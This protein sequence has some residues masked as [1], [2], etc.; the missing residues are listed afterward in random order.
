MYQN[1]YPHPRMIACV[2]G[3]FAFGREVTFKISKDF[4]REDSLEF[5]KQMWKNFT[6]GS[7]KLNFVKT[8]RRGDFLWKIGNPAV[9]ELNPEMSYGV[10]TDENGIAIKGDSDLSLIHGFYTLLQIIDPV[11]LK[12]GEECFS[13]NCGYIEDAPGIGFRCMHLSVKQGMTLTE[14]RKYIRFA[15]FMKFSHIILEYYGLLRFDCLP[16]ISWPNAYTKEEIKPLIDEARIMGME[17]IPM[18]NTLGHASMGELMDCKHVILDQ[19]PRL[20]LL[21]E[22]TGWSFCLSNPETRNLIRAASEEVIEISGPGSYFHM[23]LD[24]SLDFATCNICS[25]KNKGDLLSQFVNDTAREMRSKGRRT[26]IWGDMLLEKKK[27]DPNEAGY[28]GEKHFYVANGTEEMP[29]HE[30]LEK[31]DKDVI[32]V[33]WQYYTNDKENKTAKYISSLGYDVVPASWNRFANMQLLAEN[34]GANNYFGYMS[35]SWRSEKNNA[36]LILY[37]GDV[38]WQGKD[39]GKI[40]SFRLE[41][42]FHSAGNL[43]RKLFPRCVTYETAG[44]Y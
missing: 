44:W 32:I 35:T 24:E 38:A 17:V 42:R 10:Y 25:H 36:D 26:M 41:Q 33:D 14:L 30:A 16:E 5:L 1:I 21:F 8:D 9:K 37:S 6:F 12:M 19:N 3:Q 29:T 18:F 27:F 7:C 39:A 20:A 43:Q 13:V 15:G 23:G 11:N 22:P 31:I 4:A 40:T 28:N 34:A 2:D